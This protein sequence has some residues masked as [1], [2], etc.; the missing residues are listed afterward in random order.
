MSLTHCGVSYSNTPFTFSLS[1]LIPSGPITTPKNPTSLTFYLHFSGFTYRSFSSSLLITSATNSSYS[2]SISIP[3]ITSSINTA[4]FPILI[5]SLNSSFIM[6][7]NIAGE[8]VSLKNI[9]IGSKGPSSVVKATFYLSSSLILTLLYP[10]LKSIFI[11]IFFIPIF[12]KTSDIKGR[13]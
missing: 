13:G 8:L 3:T 11:K 2:S 4:T 9:T 5:K 12:S 1:I 10:H 6:I 7:W